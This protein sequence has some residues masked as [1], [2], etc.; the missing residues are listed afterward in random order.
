MWVVK[1]FLFYHYDGT[2]RVGQSDVYI[3][4]ALDSDRI[5]ATNKNQS[6]IHNITKRITISRTIRD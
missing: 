3:H 6:S 1:M 2:V 4:G 5:Q